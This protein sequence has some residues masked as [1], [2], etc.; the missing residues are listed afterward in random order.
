MRKILGCQALL[1]RAIV[2]NVHC[3]DNWE[4][5]YNTRENCGLIVQHIYKSLYKLVF[6]TYQQTTHYGPGQ[7]AGLN[8]GAELWH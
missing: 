4:S 3:T 7:H 2:P 5:T 1:S 8:P 6:D